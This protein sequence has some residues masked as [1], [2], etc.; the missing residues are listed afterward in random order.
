M[1]VAIIAN[2]FQEDYIIDLLNSIT[3][4]NHEIEFIGSSIY[5]EKPLSKN[6]KF[7]KLRG[8]HSTGDNFI[9]KSARIFRYYM[10][11]VFYLLFGKTRLIHVQWLRFNFFEGVVFAF[12]VRLTGKKLVYTAHDV[13]PHMKN[14]LYNRIVFYLV[15]SACSH[16]VV[17]TGFIKKRLMNEFKVRSSKISVLKHGVYT[18]SDDHITR[19]IAR[20][21]FDIDTKARVFLF[22]GIITKYKGLDLLFAAFD[23]LLKNHPESRLIVAGEIAADYTVEFKET[24]KNYTGD[25]IIKLYK[26]ID[27]ED[28]PW[29]FKAADVVVLPYLEASQSGVLFMSYAFGRPVI[30][31][32]M[33]GFPYDIAVD[34]TGLLF[35]PG[36]KDSLYNSLNE[37][38]LKYHEFFSKAEDRIKKFSSENYSWDKT[39]D[40]LIKLYETITNY[41]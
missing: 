27:N 22:F 9:T 39:G 1:R 41:H 10:R 4:K 21:R 5:E 37:F 36:N 16:I 2:N 35:E 29:L 20:K 32:N 24:D 30:A 19:E 33:G 15:Y 28:V 18:V 23:Q 14:N 13:L 40:D 38:N 31:P 8:D 25:E 12:F 34:N 11:L 7:L 17:H 6:L 26:R 3:D